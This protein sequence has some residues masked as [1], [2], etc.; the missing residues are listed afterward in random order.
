M[1]T[2]LHC[3]LIQIFRFPVCVWVGCTRNARGSI[4]ESAKDFTT[5]CNSAPSEILAIIALQNKERILRR[6]LE[7]IR[8]NLAHAN[9]FFSEQG[10]NFCWIDPTAGSVDLPRWLGAGSVEDFCRGVL[11][12]QGVM[13]VP[14]SIFEYPGNY[15]RIGLG[16][17]NFPEALGR[18]INIYNFF[19]INGKES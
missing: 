8:A 14:G 15:F 3:P 16:R 4:G 17:K 7:I 9:K 5:I 18:V 1:R 10:G 13:I 11:D 2:A 19:G 12:Q 6:N